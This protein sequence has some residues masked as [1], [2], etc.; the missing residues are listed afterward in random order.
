M[1]KI[2]RFESIAKTVLVCALILAAIIATSCSKKKD[3]PAETAPDTKT[4]DATQQM[5]TEKSQQPQIAVKQ[6]ESQTQAAKP[7][8]Q[9]DEISLEQ[10][11]QAVEKEMARL[12]SERKKAPQPEKPEARQVVKRVEGEF[13]SLTDSD[14]KIGWIME[15]TI[16]NPESTLDVVAKA[17]DD[18]DVEVRLAAMEA[19]I[20]NE[21]T[22]PKLVEVVI[23]ALGDTD[24]QIRQSAIETC[25]FMSGP[26]AAKILTYALGDTS[27]AVR[28]AAMQVADDRDNTVKVE[29]FK[30]GITSSYQ[31]IRENTL[32]S[33]ID[34]S[35][36][37]A[38]DVLITGL[39]D[40]D[41][42]FREEVNSAIG[43]LI[44]QE[45]ETYDQ[46]KKWWDD[47]RDRFDEELFEK[48]DI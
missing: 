1:N 30:A 18:N 28:I 7:Q 22:G 48:D 24:E 44:D 17:L 6:T 41:P 47:N 32:S 35:S 39:K 27:E 33:L 43:F 10:K 14:E 16:S 31:D 37:E 42:D 4:A 36:P 20:D 29:V 19:L 9:P 11:K 45:F 46:A 38:V 15:T 25:G 5:Q 2:I 34:I 23:K 8:V 12:L 3:Q 21:S 13:E 40:P 26:E